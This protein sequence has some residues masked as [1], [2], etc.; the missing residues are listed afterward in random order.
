MLDKLLYILCDGALI[1]I[2]HLHMVW[3]VKDKDKETR[4]VH[5][6]IVVAW[7]VEGLS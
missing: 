2:S 6:T 3:R 7:R 1:V 5:V 4:V